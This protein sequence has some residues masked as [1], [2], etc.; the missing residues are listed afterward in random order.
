[1]VCGGAWPVAL[2]V[3]EFRLTDLELEGFQPCGHG[4]CLAV[5]HQLAGW[6]G[7]RCK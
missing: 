2:Q 6:R 3:P 7:A 4:G 1:M 5:V